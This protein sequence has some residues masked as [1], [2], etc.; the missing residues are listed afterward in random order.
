MRR[1]AIAPLLA[2][3]LVLGLSLSAAACATY[4]DDLGRAQHAIDAGQHE[5]ALAI[6]RILEPDL[7]RLSVADRARYAY[8]RGT[9]DRKM[10]Y[11][12][13][14]RHWLSMAMAIE[15]STPRSLPAEWSRR[16]AAALQELNEQV[17]TAG[18]QALAGGP[19][20]APALVPAAAGAPDDEQAPPAGEAQ[21]APRRKLDD[22]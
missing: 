4:E 3:A 9:T 16:A 8:L 7:G 2:P 15:A 20:T 1:L 21:P 13:E 14:A 18:I 12:A 10:G 5:R 6:F 22:W 17:Y 19:R 11:D